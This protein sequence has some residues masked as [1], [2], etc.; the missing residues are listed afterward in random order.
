V[1][2]LPS[3]PF[4]AKDWISDERV[5]S[6]TLEQAGAY[7]HLLAANWVEGSLPH[8]LCILS[9][10]AM[11]RKCIR[12]SQNDASFEKH[13]W[14]KIS[15]LFVDVGNGRICNRRLLKELNEAKARHD[16]LVE[17]GKRGGVASARLKGA[18]SIHPHPHPHHDESPLP[19]TG[20]SECLAHAPPG[21]ESGG[22]GTG[23]D[24]VPIEEAI[25]SYVDEYN[26]HVR[27]LMP[28]QD[29]VT[30]ISN[31]NR[32]ELLAR[33][34]Q[35]GPGFW[36][37]LVPELRKLN[38]WARSRPWFNFGYVVSAKGCTKILQGTYRK[39]TR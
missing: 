20:G 5:R 38:D 16:L 18:S 24:E 11:Y 34:D 14:S 4:W 6:M 33:M 26:E 8:R 29:P 30:T 7:I 22:N 19:P 3:F 21:E 39:D 1:N 10:L 36:N 28:N 23:G 25:Q 32:R 2:P 31:A 15:D 17:S 27:P 12:K 35:H 37:L 13:V 9:A